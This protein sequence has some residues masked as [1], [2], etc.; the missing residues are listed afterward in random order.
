VSCTATD[1][2]NNRSTASF[3]IAVQDTTAPVLNVPGNQTLEALSSAGAPATFVAATATDAV[4]ADVAILCSAASGDIFP[5]GATPVSCTATDDAG[6]RSTA[7]FTI[8]VQD[9]T[10]PVL[11]VPGNQTLESLSAAGAPATFAA[12]GTDAVD[13]S[14]AIAC[15]AAS[16]DTFPLGTTIVTCTATDDAGNATSGAFSVTVRDTTAPLLSDVTPST[17]ML[18]P[19]N[20]NMVEVGLHYTA[21]DAVSAA[22]CRVT[23]ASN[24]PVNATGDG[25]TAPDWQV[26]SPTQV[27][28]RAERAGG[29]SGRIYTL[30]VTCTDASGNTATDT[31]TVSVPESMGQ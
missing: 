9:T 7:S 20:H 16:G 4:D 3:T 17:G 24:D 21:T 15:S 5:L 13:A 2:A 12:T 1:D 19:P 6:N 11:N 8:A 29:G 25:D 30:T 28:L 18:W 27:E 31:A 22:A 23:V 10:A 14:L 26:L